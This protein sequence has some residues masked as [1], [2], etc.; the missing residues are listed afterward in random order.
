MDDSASYGHNMVDDEQL[1]TVSEVARMLR[2]SE[3]TIRRK[4]HSGE[5]PGAL[6]IGAGDKAPLRVRSDVLTRWV[7]GDAEVVR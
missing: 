6:R 3:V 7:Y 1:L 2:Q 5:L 4:L